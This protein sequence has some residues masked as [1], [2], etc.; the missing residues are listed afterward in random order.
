MTE[1]NELWWN[2]ESG[3][4]ETSY[5]WESFCFSQVFGPPGGKTVIAEYSSFWQPKKTQ[6][7]VCSHT[8]ATIKYVTVQES[9]PSKFNTNPIVDSRNT[10][11]SSRVDLRAAQHT[12]RGPAPQLM[13]AL[14][15]SSN[16][17]ITVRRVI[18]FFQLKYSLPEAGLSL[19]ETLALPQESLL[20]KTND[21]VQQDHAK[22]LQKPYPIND[23]KAEEKVNT[24]DSLRR[25]T[26]IRDGLFKV[27]P[28]RQRDPL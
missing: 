16:R 5:E 17:S 3:A 14:S 24:M 12:N 11:A 23:Q 4:W 21:W 22:N 25:W 19:L 13:A 27:K 20:L 15:S 7:N 2:A 9:W 1:Y 10:I 8:H 18:E 6:F 26:E 28:K